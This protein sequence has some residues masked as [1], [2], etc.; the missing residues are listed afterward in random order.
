MD[1]ACFDQ[2][3]T[4]SAF[5]IIRSHESCQS[6]QTGKT[7]T[8]GSRFLKHII[9]AIFTCMD[10]LFICAYDTEKDEYLIVLDAETVRGQCTKWDGDFESILGNFFSWIRVHLIAFFKDNEIEFSEQDVISSID[11]MERS[12]EKDGKKAEIELDKVSPGVGTLFP[13]PVGPVLEKVV[14]H[15]DTV[16]EILS[17]LVPTAVPVSESIGS[18]KLTKRPQRTRLRTQRYTPEET[19]DKK[20]DRKTTAKTSERK[21]KNDRTSEKAEIEII[22]T[23]K[24][25]KVKK[26][27]NPKKK[28]ATEEEEEEEGK[29]VDEV[30]NEPT[31]LQQAIE[32]Y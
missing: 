21:K 20:N 7:F 27:R 32:Q 26:Q 1:L 13:S 11:Q 24:S 28:V 6:T 10:I 5:G 2:F 22:D 29:F 17:P 19:T 9:V 8:S 31:L 3:L 16:P 12:T 23:G 30:D 18:P 15:F 4:A 14:T 25:T